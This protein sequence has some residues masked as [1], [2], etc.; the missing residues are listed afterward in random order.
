MNQEKMKAK[1]K[2]TKLGRAKKRKKSEHESKW[3]RGH[4]RQ[5]TRKEWRFPGKAK[6]TIINNINTYCSTFCT[7]SRHTYLV[8]EKHENSDDIDWPMAQHRRDSSIR[9]ATTRMS[10]PFR[11]FDCCPSSPC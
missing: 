6:Q 3:T 8:R 10:W 11:V 4:T 2:D 1:R 9:T 7:C 5:G